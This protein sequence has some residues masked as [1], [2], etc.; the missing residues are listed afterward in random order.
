[1]KLLSIITFITPA[2][3]VN[4]I[5][6]INLAFSQM[7][8]AEVEIECNAFKVGDKYVKETP[9]F[10]PGIPTTRGTAFDGQMMLISS[11]DSYGCWCDMANG[12]RTGG[13]R[14]TNEL[15]AACRDLH[16]SYN[17]I[18][19]DDP[20]CLPRT[21][22]A[23]LG[24][25]NLPLSV[26]SPLTTPQAQ[27]AIYNPPDSCGYRTCVVEAQFLRTTVS[28]VYAGD[29]EWLDMW[30]DNDL[31]HSPQGQFDN[32]QCFTQ[33]NVMNYGDKQCCG[34]YPHRFPY[35]TNKAQCCNEVNSP[36]GS[37]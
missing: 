28:P 12:L 10:C 3:A 6:S 8:D 2:F 18:T 32:A 13:G 22:D 19:H 36:L 25:Y 1:M 24:E 21:L 30:N 37:C 14:P 9:D 16:R 20:T 34:E 7:S 17:C 29:V 5:D 35:Y 26:T 31:A 11:A 33:N 4:K 27:C 23:S 15:D